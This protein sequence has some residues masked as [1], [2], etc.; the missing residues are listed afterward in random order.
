MCV[1][2][3]VT[4]HHHHQQQQRIKKQN[5]FRAFKKTRR[6]MSSKFWRKFLSVPEF[7]SQPDHQSR[8]LKTFSNVKTLKNW[9]PEKPSLRSSSMC[10]TKMTA[11]PRKRKDWGFQ[12]R[13]EV[14]GVPRVMEIPVYQLSIKVRGQPVQIGPGDSTDSHVEGCHHQQA[15]HHCTVL[16]WFLTWR[17]NG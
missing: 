16:F 14:R 8:K 2:G 9:P 6:T 3:K 11:S 1:G 13:T 10:S 17:N 4:D 12:H 5:R 15:N 7:L